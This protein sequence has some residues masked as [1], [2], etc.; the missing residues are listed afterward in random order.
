MPDKERVST[1]TFLN[2]D[3]NDISNMIGLALD[4]YEYSN[5]QKIRYT[6]CIEETLLRWQEELAPDT[7]VLLKRRDVKNS[8]GFEISIPG[9]K[10]EAMQDNT[11]SD[12]LE[13]LVPRIKSGVGQELKYYYYRGRNT[14]DISLPKKKV[15]QTLFTKNVQFVSFPI[16]LQLV[17]LSISSTVDSIMLSFLNQDSMSAASLVSS[18][19][20]IFTACIGA[21]TTSM[22]T[23]FGKYWSRRDFDQAARVF[24]FVL[25]LGIITGFMFC[26]LTFCF[27][28]AIMTLFTDVESVQLLGVQYMRYLS[29]YFIFTALSEVFLC[30][31]RNAGA[32]ALS[33]TYVV[34]AQF[35]N[36]VMNG[37]FIFGL[38]G[39]KPM[40]IKGAALSTTLSSVML[41]VLAASWFIRK[42]YIRLKPDHFLH[43]SKD[44]RK[45]YNGIM[46]PHLCSSISWYF[47][48]SV[49]ASVLG[50]LNADVLAAD[51]IKTAVVNFFRCFTNGTGQATGL[52]QS[53]IV[54]QRQ[55]AKA[56]RNSKYIIRYC[57]WAGLF[58]SLVFAALIPVYP[59]VFGEISEKAHYYLN[60]MLIV[61]VFR[62]FLGIINYNTNTG[63]FYIAG[64]TKSLL[65]IDTI[66]KW[67][68]IILPAALGTW[69][70]AM[71]EMII[72][73]LVNAD[74]I[75]S[76]PF[77]Q[78]HYRSGKWLK[79][80]EKSK[81]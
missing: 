16:I 25:K 6:F 30:F 12:I 34:V 46:I 62:N 33:S 38:F 41:L 75:F 15:E 59:M 65:I 23:T 44:V 55:F 8:F 21:Y 49:I 37:I 57:F 18:L 31:M 28:L 19:C 26:L 63:V 13:A 56:E 64:D 14:I 43:F 5:E 24:A 36:I 80:L 22:T 76:F 35:A 73:L 78:A 58:S 40:G 60:F 69:V 54:G 53:K 72:L 17:L 10:V 67:G 68:V 50:H 32:V 29:L 42:R 51:A 47:G 1:I 81:N 70:F 66:I 3:T 77:K 61:C 45:E 11:S 2:K 48:N 9:K 74:E 20:Y 52:L 27:P 39:I 7:E 79:L 71:P 4:R